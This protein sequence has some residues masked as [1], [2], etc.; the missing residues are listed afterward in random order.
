MKAPRSIRYRINFNPE[1]SQSRTKIV[2]FA[3]IS[4][5]LSVFAVNQ[6]FA[7]GKD[8]KESLSNDVD[9]ITDAAERSKAGADDFSQMQKKIQRDEG[10]AQIAE[11]EAVELELAQIKEAKEAEQKKLEAIAARE[12]A[13]RRKRE[14]SEREDQIRSEEELR[15]DV[16]KE[17]G[18]AP[19]SA[20][21][22][23]WKGFSE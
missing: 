10:Q 5:V 20:E 8:K 9:I 4:L 6:L 18:I 11:A 16:L 1:K 12:E 19:I 21:E 15:R 14:K 22:A 2:A 3:V 7:K 13:D 17:D 23:R